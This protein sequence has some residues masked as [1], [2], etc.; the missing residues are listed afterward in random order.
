[1]ADNEAME[2]QNNNEGEKT[3]TQAEV[4][5]IIAARVARA[6]KGMP[7]AEELAAF[8][9]WKANQ[10]SE[11]EKYAAVVTERDS[12]RAEIVTAKSEAAKLKRELYVAKKG[13]E[14]ED[15]EFIT[16]KAEKMVSDTKTFEQAVD[17]LT[18]DREK[19][20]RFDWAAQVGN[21]EGRKATESDV[22]NALIRGAGGK[23]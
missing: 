16:Y 4:D 21:G 10:Q 17:E 23:L 15:A 7:N 22:M 20:A 12:A 13:L 2:Q 19:K 8:N 6:T 3:F 5:K 18:K 1:M 9:T 14:G 11:A